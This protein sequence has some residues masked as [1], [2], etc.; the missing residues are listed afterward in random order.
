M[1]L[2]GIT[3]GIG[4]GKSTAGNF[5]LGEGYS[6]VDTDVVARSTVEPGQPALLEIR[7]VFGDGIVD[8]TGELNREEL[9]KIIFSD[10]ASR[11]KLEAILHP[12]IRNAWQQEVQ[13]WREQGQKFGFVTIP[14]LFETNAQKLFDSV[15]CVACSSKT[16]MERLRSRGWNDTQIQQRID[17]QW[18]VEKKMAASDYLV[19]T[20]TTM[21]MHHEQLRR[22]LQTV[23]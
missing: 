23:S 14:L 17:A 13:G 11:Q 4:M 8:N 22:I 2:F 7:A 6:L 12:R 5:L 10:P 15:I 3:G 21:E 18:P 19:W 20:D 16:Q 9:A 1:I